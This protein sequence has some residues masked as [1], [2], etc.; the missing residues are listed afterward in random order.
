[1]TPQQIAL[2][3]DSWL[4][5]LPIRDAAA[6]MFYT[7]LFSLDPEV[8]ALFKGDMNEQGRKLMTMINIAVN[9]LDKLDTIVPAVQDLGRR[10]AK[11]GVMDAHYDTVAAALLWTLGQGLGA[12][13]TYDVK[14]AW[15][16]AYTVL[17]STMKQAATVPA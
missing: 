1:M 15:V 4:K 17:A 13:F 9:A 3:K 11:Y 7:K 6:S 14:Q 16:E 2:V 8:E 5:V 12:A 10:H